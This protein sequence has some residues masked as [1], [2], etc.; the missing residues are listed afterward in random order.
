MK[1][2]IVSLFILCVAFGG[3]Y[4]SI[5][6]AHRY[7]PEENE[8]F[9]QMVSSLEAARSYPSVWIPDFTEDGVAMVRCSRAR[10]FISFE[11]AGT[12][13]SGQDFHLYEKAGGVAASGA[14]SV[15]DYCYTRSNVVVSHARIS[16]RE[17][18]VSSGTCSYAAIGSG[19]K[20]NTYEFHR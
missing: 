10:G 5:H 12:D 9:D 18:K 13:T 7:P 16:G 4:L 20:E 17:G 3:W 8:C 11:V 6:V 1:L 19:G 15:F 14:D 2:T